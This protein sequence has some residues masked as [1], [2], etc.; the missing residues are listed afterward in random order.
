L[1]PVLFAQNNFEEL[2]EEL[3][4]SVANY[5]IYSDTKEG[6]INQLKELLSYSSSA[7]QRYDITKNCMRSINP[8]SPIQRW[9]TLERV[10]KLLKT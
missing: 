8:T 4:Q 10:F 9:F 1:F 2:L 5:A 6:E 7:S 3:D